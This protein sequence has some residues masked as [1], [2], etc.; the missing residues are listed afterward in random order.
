M[1]VWFIPTQTA[2]AEVQKH[3]L[4]TDL[5]ISS[6]I[7]VDE[8]ISFSVG[9]IE[10]DVENGDTW[11]Q[12]SSVP[13]DDAVVTVTFQQGEQQYAVTLT[14]EQEGRYNGVVRLPETGLW[15]V[16][17]EASVDRPELGAKTASLDTNLMVQDSAAG[18][19]E[20]TAEMAKPD[21]APSNSGTIIAIGIA[22]VLLII[23]ILLLR[24]FRKP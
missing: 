20:P 8:E 5:A 24:K 23:G 14:P 4:I 13:V 3:I 12:E 7:V 10:V 9:V 16:I 11:R 17:I 21:A 18:T 15:E 1:L 2:E 22:L 19:D 6:K